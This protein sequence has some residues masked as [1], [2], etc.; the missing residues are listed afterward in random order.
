MRTVTALVDRRDTR[1]GAARHPVVGFVFTHI[2]SSFS[3]PVGQASRAH[4]PRAICRWRSSSVR[5][6]R[7][8][9]VIEILPIREHRKDRQP[10]PGPPPEWSLSG[11]RRQE[12]GVRDHYRLHRVG[13]VREGFKMSDTPEYP[14]GDRLRIRRTASR[15]PSDFRGQ[16]CGGTPRCTCAARSATRTTRR[17]GSGPGCAHA[18]VSSS[19]RPFGSGCGCPRWSTSRLVHKAV[20]HAGRTV[21]WR[22]TGY[23]HFTS[24]FLRPLPI[25]VRC[26]REVG[27]W[28]TGL[29]TGRMRVHLRPRERLRYRQCQRRGGVR[30]RNQPSGWRVSSSYLVLPM[31]VK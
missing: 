30:S 12:A 17:L 26:Q 3:R 28:L 14:Y 27:M 6:L 10:L 20:S 31:A 21:C 11:H 18:A 22:A 16:R 23:V 24:Y 1:L 19:S 29:P 4:A 25:R 9:S 15:V 13:A 2:E 5:I 7:I 8:L